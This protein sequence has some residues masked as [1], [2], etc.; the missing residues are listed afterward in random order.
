M[1]TMNTVN[2]LSEPYL[3]MLKFSELGVNVGHVVKGLA[4]RL[5]D[6]QHV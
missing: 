2:D 3:L 5:T 4:D 6:V 1:K